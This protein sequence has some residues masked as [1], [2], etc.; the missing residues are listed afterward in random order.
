LRNKIYRESDGEKIYGEVFY[1][2]VNNFNYYFTE[3][4]VF[5]DGMIRCWELMNLS[6][7]KKKLNS[8]WIKI[9]LP[10]DSEFHIHSLGTIKL[11][12][13]IPAKTNEDFIKEIEDT[14]IELSGGKG[15]RT[16]CVELFKQYL[17][18]DNKQNYLKLKKGFID[19]PSHQKLLFEMVD[20]KDPL[21]EMMEKENEEKFTQEQRKFMLND[22]FY[23]DWNKQEFIKTTHNNI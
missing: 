13:F 17:L 14:I 5:S 11:S 6:E 12:E 3:I 15:R 4:T 20:Y 9:N 22:Y 1:G 2:F 18:N 16:K 7:F 21:I 23:E 8:G 19:L 10:T